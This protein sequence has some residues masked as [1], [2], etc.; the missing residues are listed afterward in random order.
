[1]PGHLFLAWHGLLSLYG[2]DVTAAAPGLPTVLAWL[3]A[4]GIA[5]AVAAFAVVAWHVPRQHDLVSDVLAVA[6]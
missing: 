4:P 2:A 1:M 3:H 6:S 5:L